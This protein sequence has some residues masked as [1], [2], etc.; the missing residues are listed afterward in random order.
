M[1]GRSQFIISSPGNSRAVLTG[2]VSPNV[3]IV[4]PVKQ[5]WY[6]NDL[7]TGQLTNASGS[8][9]W[10]VTAESYPNYQCYVDYTAT[11]ANQVPIH[12]TS[13]KHDINSTI[14]ISVQDRDCYRQVSVPIYSYDGFTRD[15]GGGYDSYISFASE[16]DI[17]TLVPSILF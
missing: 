12:A 16:V 3:L 10:F 13:T 1:H 8:W 5:I 7:I 4:D 6:I 9:S 17:Y 15:F 2:Y 11:Y 14:Q